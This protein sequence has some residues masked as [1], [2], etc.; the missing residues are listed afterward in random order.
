MNA[1]MSPGITL[2]AK[3]SWPIAVRVVMSQG[4]PLHDRIPQEGNDFATGGKAGGGLE[5]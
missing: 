4:R 3:P 2:L 5:Y 1:H